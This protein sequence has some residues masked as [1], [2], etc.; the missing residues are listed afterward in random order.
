MSLFA[1]EKKPIET[2]TVTKQEKVASMGKWPVGG[3]G[4]RAQVGELALG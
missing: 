1:D 3:I 2:K 4:F